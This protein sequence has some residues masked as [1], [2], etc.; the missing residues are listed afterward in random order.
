MFPRREILSL[1]M[2]LSCSSPSV[3]PDIILQVP[4]CRARVRLFMRLPPIQP[5]H[6]CC[7][8]LELLRIGVRLQTKWESFFL[9]AG[10]ASLMPEGNV[11]FKRQDP[12]VAWGGND[13]S[14]RRHRPNYRVAA[15]CNGFCYSTGSGCPKAKLP[16]DGGGGY[17]FW[18]AREVRIARGLNMG[19]VQGLWV[20]LAITFLLPAN[21]LHTN[22]HNWQN[23]FMLLQAQKKLWDVMSHLREYLFLESNPDNWQ[24]PCCTLT[25][26]AIDIPWV[27]N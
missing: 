7:F 8:W 22:F 23:M 24:K 15:V 3:R 6:M 25:C 14:Q 11:N 4:R 19:N 12:C 5:P 16:R 27:P 20:P 18:P 2:S 13:I 21:I 26:D 1:N 17:C 10:V 9:W